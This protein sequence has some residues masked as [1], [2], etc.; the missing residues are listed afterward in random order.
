MVSRRL[1]CGQSIE[2][3]H[4]IFR[5]AAIFLGLGCFIC[6][7]AS[8]ADLPA[9]SA[10]MTLVTLKLN[11]VPATDAINALAKAADVPIGILG[12]TDRSERFGPPRNVTIDV[13]RQPF[14]ILLNEICRQGGYA[15]QLVDSSSRAK[16]AVGRIPGTMPPQLPQ[17]YANGFLTFITSANHTHTLDYNRPERVANAF[18]V[19]LRSY[20]DPKIELLRLTPNLEVTEAIDDFGNSLLPTAAIDAPPRAMVQGGA[21]QPPGVRLGQAAAV[22]FDLT[23]ELNY[24]PEKGSMLKSL[25]GNAKFQVAT[26][27]ATWE[28]DDVSDIQGK[29]REFPGGKFTI[30]SLTKTENPQNN[31]PLDTLVQSDHYVLSFLIDYDPAV[32]SRPGDDPNTSSQF[33]R[34][35]IR[36]IDGRGRV[37]GSPAELSS[38]RKPYDSNPRG[39]DIKF[40]YT[41]MADN[42]PS[43]RPEADTAPAKIIWRIPTEMRD[44]TIPV[45]FHDVPIP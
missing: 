8:A 20:P 24:K 3:F 39:L 32:I 42:G 14:W 5:V 12:A 1:T 30:Q 37:I 11:D 16:V 18:T 23:A 34:N 27:T 7:Y 29:E 26:K 9:S 43:T 35:N 28:L 13:Q 40:S 45:E 36:V 22:Y 4:R 41:V 2:R 33:L 38:L 15:P 44:V 17:S 19:R 21:P 6:P 31:S 25:K 10:E